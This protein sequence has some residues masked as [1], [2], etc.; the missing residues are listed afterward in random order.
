MLIK[1]IWN[2]TIAAFVEIVEN[3]LSHIYAENEFDE[4]I[5]SELTENISVL[6]L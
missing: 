5:I 2:L 1:N 4:R 6:N 3:K